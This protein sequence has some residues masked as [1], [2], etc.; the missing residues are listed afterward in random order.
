LAT[1]IRSPK[2]GAS[3]R[4]L[5]PGAKRNETSEQTPVSRSEEPSTGR[6]LP[7]GSQ[8]SVSRS[9]R[10]H[11]QDH[12][13]SNAKLEENPFA[14]ALKLANARTEE[15]EQRL[16]ALEAEIEQRREAASETGYKDGHAEGLEQGLDA[17][18]AQIKVLEEIVTQLN[19]RLESAI[20]EVED[21]AVE[22]AFAAVGKILF[23]QLTKR[24]VVS[25]IVRNLKD[26][27]AFDARQ[28]IVHVSPDDFKLLTESA[29]AECELPDGIRLVADDR[30]RYGGC[31]VE[32]DSGNLDARLE[33]QLQELL[34]LFTKVRHAGREV[35]A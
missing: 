14:E 5:V 26:R 3:Q 21:A 13:E 10:T 9:E 24:E 27:L 18:R 33:V 34:E 2:V 22:L 12:R 31:I 30:V 35:S 29:G 1:I 4:R 25:S 20:D 15:T 8:V 23:G 11:R 17:Y 28:L 16:E 7:S 32:A 19:R 6:G